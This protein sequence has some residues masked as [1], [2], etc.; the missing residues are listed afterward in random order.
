MTSTI[1]MDVI[2]GRLQRLIAQTGLPAVESGLHYGLP[3]FKVGGK[4]FVT[5]KNNETIVLSLPI[6]RKEQLMEMAPEIYFQTDHYVGWPFLPLR[7]AAI[8]DEELELRLIEAWRYRA[9]KKLL[10]TFG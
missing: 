3:A 10:A 9:P 8:G 4:A 7:I 1:D 2:A 5:V 6:D